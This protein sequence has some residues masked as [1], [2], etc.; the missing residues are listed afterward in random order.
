MKRFYSI[1]SP[2]FSVEESITESEYLAIIGDEVHRPFASAVY[3]GEMALDAV[4]EEY[5]ETVAAIV[6]NRTARWGDYADWPVRG[7][8]KLADILLGGEMQMKRSEAH[9]LRRIIHTAAVSLDD[10]DASQAAVLFPRLKQDGGLVK[11]G[12][13]INWGGV[14]KRAAVDLWDTAENSPD[15]APALWEDLAYRDGVRIIPEIITVG[16][17]FAKGERGWWGDTLYESVIE[18]N[19]WTPEAYP[20]GWQLVEE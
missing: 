12:T 3:K 5:R 17:A 20:A 1:L 15:V 11:A 7:S 4:P 13:R 8:G 19:V 10:K 9:T 14:V 6:V 18:A 16:L 2:D